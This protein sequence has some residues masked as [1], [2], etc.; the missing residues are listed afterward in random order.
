MF[1]IYFN[2]LNYIHNYRIERKKRKN[3]KTDVFKNT[4]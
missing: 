3:N 4:Q 1:R 2:F